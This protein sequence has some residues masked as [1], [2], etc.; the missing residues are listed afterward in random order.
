MSLLALSW[1]MLKIEIQ[2]GKNLL[3]VF[4]SSPIPLLSLPSALGISIP[5]LATSLQ[6][7]HPPMCS[8]HPGRVGFQHQSSGPPPLPGMPP[9]GLP[10]RPGGGRMSRAEASVL[11]SRSRREKGKESGP[12]PASDSGVRENTGRR[13]KSSLHP[14]HL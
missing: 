7:P 3:D 9:D 13:H 4:F 14:E 6:M 11:R 1:G 5:G 8:K 10:R 12:L 2:V